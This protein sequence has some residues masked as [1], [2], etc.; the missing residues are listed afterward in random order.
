[1]GRG[2]NTFVMHLDMMQD[3][4]NELDHCFL[5][6]TKFVHEMSFN[7]FFHQTKLAFHF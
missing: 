7:F 1:M 4:S 3:G 2:N 6:S 5:Q